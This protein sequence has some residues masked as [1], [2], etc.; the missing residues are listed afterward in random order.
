[1]KQRKFTLIELLVVI[2]IIAILAAMLLPAL[3]AA[4]SRA[5]ASSCTANL[6]QV[7]VGQTMYSA[8]FD[9]WWVQQPGNSS[10]IGNT[11]SIFMLELGYI[12]SPSVFFCPTL[13]P[14]DCKDAKNFSGAK[15]TYTNASGGT[16]K[17][18]ETTYGAA[19]LYFSQYGYKEDSIKRKLVNTGAMPDPSA[20]F[21]I[22]D[23]SV[24][25]SGAGTGCYVIQKNTDWACVYFGHGSDTC[26]AVFYDGHVGT[27]N[28]KEMLSFE[29]W[30]TSSAYA[31]Y[32]HTQSSGEVKLYTGTGDRLY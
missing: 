32:A 15:G 10:A 18:R 16:S 29:N 12:E 2:A 6:K 30:S 26:N 3:S 5:Q 11:W 24:G 7:G 27:H 9:G 17:Y 25:A 21:A 14:G 1:M 19:I 28:L 31:Y 23:S 8:D 13:L 22:A 4:R 20:L